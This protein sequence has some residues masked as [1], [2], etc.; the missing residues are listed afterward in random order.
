MLGFGRLFRSTVRPTAISTAIA[1]HSFM[2]WPW[3][4]SHPTRI[5][6]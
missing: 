4:E 1:S 6:I 2:L 5:D 3:C